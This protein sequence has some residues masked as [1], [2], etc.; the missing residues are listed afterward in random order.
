MRFSFLPILFFFIT[1]SVL[2]QNLTLTGTV[3]SAADEMTFPGASVMVQN[4]KDTT[5]VKGN[6]TDFNGNF[7][8]DGLK[9]G[10]YLVTIAF[11]GYDK[12]HQLIKLEKDLS[13]G[14]IA[15]KESTKMLEAIEVVGKPI[16]AMQKGDT[17]QFNANAY[18]TAGDA[19]AQELVQKIP[20]ISIEDGNVQANGESVQTILVDGKPFFGGDVKAALQN[21]PAEVIA[22]IQI[23]D[24]PSDKAAMSG[25]DDGEQQKTINIITKPSRRRG[26]FG[27]ST[28]GAGT[29]DSYQAGAS[30]NMFNNDRRT[31]VTGLSNNVN[32]TNYSADPNSLGDRARNGIVN[33]NNIGINFS[34]DLNDKIEVHGSYQYSRLEN[35]ENRSRLRDFAAASSST[36]QVYTEQSSFE[37]VDATHRFNFKLDYKIDDNNRLIIRPNVKLQNESIQSAFAGSTVAGADPINA[38]DNSSNKKYK[39]YDYGNSIY[40]SHKFNKEGRT[41]TT[42]FNTGYHTNEDF[43]ERTAQNFFYN[44]E[45]DSTSVIDQQTRLDRSAI[46]WRAHMSYTEP[47]SERSMIELE[48][49][50]SNKINDSD[51]LTYNAGDAQQ[52]LEID[53]ALSNTFNSKYL[54][55]EIEL[56]YQYKFEKLRLQVEAEYQIANMNNEQIFPKPMDQHRLFTSILPSA[57][58]NYKFSDS[59]RIEMNYRTWTNEPS[60][61]QLQDV[62]NNTNPLQLHAGN[63]NLNQTYY[64][65]GRA[66]YFLNNVDTGKS[67][68]ASIESTI[69]KD[70]VTNSIF[71]ASEPTPITD[72]I[73]LETGSQ[74]TRPENVDGYYQVRSYASYGMPMEAIKSNV[75]IRG[76]MSYVRRPGLINDKVNYSNASNF[77]VGLSLSS[78]ISEDID[79]YVSSWSNYNIVENS[80]RPSMNN[81]YYTQSSRASYKWVFGDGFVYRANLR[82]QLNT[83]LS[84]G[85]D[86]TSL[87]L[88]MSAGKKFLKNDLAEISLNVYDLL[89]QNNN[90][91]R[92][93]TGLYVEDSQSTVLQRYFMLTF[94]YNIRHFSAGSKMEDFEEH[95]L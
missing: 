84:Q 33:T 51:K 32:M 77:R 75:R 1:S 59:K 24:K 76:G 21:L 45:E 50:A 89:Q 8:I 86:N 78:N 22:S 53:T 62:I 9:A 83:G 36:D 52:Y 82:H 68:Y 39:D 90:V 3:Q 29:N 55:Q 15:L 93:V 28:I 70:L 54:N 56:G 71:I 60:I 67:L 80:L 91:S 57:K 12:H 37:K 19:S 2:A 42:G 7:K 72:D 17:A 35:K 87:L 16:A 23:F 46:S 20:G 13:L 44:E 65:W 6:V 64:H 10:S 92:S 26:Q 43:A 25:F 63:P 27:K 41:I 58:I 11:V 18:K 40:Y 69:A 73:T 88:N 49:K 79:F 31:T 38:T 74:L 5:L 66:R 34:D 30:V 94:T 95:S 47:L 4:P 61:G 81:N 48:Y 14:K 85:Y